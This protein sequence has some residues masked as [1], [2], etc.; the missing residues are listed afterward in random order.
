MPKKK[1]GQNAKSSEVKEEEVKI[2]KSTGRGE[3]PPEEEEPK[4]VGAY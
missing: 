1:K 4:P 3:T 2:D